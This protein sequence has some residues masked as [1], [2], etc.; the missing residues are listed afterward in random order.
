MATT[1]KAGGRDLQL[2]PFTLDTTRSVLPK[3]KAMPSSG[4]DL[5]AFVD[6]S[7]EILVETLQGGNEGVTR[8]WFGKNV[9]IDELEPLFLAVLAAS[10]LKVRAAGEAPGEAKSP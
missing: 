1:F 2:L 10:G 9:T 5:L 3:L 8:E 4:A 6:A 7:S